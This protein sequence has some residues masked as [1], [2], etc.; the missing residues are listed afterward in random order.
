VINTTNGVIQ[1]RPKD[2]PQDTPEF[3]QPLH[4]F[5]GLAEPSAGDP[6]VIY[7]QY[8]GRFVLILMEWPTAT[9]FL[10][11]SKTSN[12]NDGWWRHSFT[13]MVVIGGTTYVGDYPGLAVDDEAIYLTANM[14]PWAGGALG[15]FLWIIPRRPACTGPDGA[16]FRRPMICAP[17]G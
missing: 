13:N 2:N 6:K 8:A 16:A 1:W 7:D 4:S 5:F 3:E 17:W 10:A 11:V 9:F 12:P 14:L 15:S